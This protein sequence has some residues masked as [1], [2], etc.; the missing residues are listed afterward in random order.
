MTSYFWL[1]CLSIVVT[2]VVGII[3]ESNDVSAVPAQASNPRLSEANIVRAAVAVNAVGSTEELHSKADPKSVMRS[4]SKVISG[5]GQHRLVV[6]DSEASLDSMYRSPEQL[7]L[8]HSLLEENSRAQKPLHHFHNIAKHGIHHAK[9]HAKHRHSFSHHVK[10]AKHAKK[11]AKHAITGK[12]HSS[13]TTTTPA[14]TNYHRVNGSRYC[15][16]WS[17]TWAIID[18]TS[19]ALCKDA[20]T[21]SS[22][23]TAANWFPHGQMCYLFS[24]CSAHGDSMVQG[25]VYLK[26]VNC[27]WEAW[28]DWSNCTATCGGGDKERRRVIAVNAS[29]GGDEC[30]G[31]NE[32]SKECGMEDC[33]TTTTIHVA[34]AES[35]NSSW[36][37]EIEEDEAA[38][39]KEVNKVFDNVQMTR[40]AMAGGGLLLIICALYTTMSSGEEEEAYDKF[41]DCRDDDGPLRTTSI[42]FQDATNIQYVEHDWDDSDDGGDFRGS[43]RG[44]AF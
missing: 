37:N 44:Y 25:Q 26:Q 10:K 34:E 17:I 21:K 18:G 22:N 33:P 2:L 20:C 11:R 8:E 1:S 35:D 12:K 19:P 41:D 24:N 31:P 4:E 42:R 9:H 36:L 38:A 29:N 15:E 6:V 23:C 5:N 30:D 13:V 16:P 27:Q 3:D 32:E 7:G 14:P 43:G 39:E 40:Y 28:Q